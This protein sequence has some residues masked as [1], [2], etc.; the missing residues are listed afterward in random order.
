MAGTGFQTST[1]NCILTAWRVGVLL[2]TNIYVLKN[3]HDLTSCA[4]KEK[5]KMLIV[6]VMVSDYGQ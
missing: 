4:Q 6:T 1:F 5:N 2:E 3:L